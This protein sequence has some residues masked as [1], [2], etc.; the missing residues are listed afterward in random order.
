MLIRAVVDDEIHQDVHVALF[1]LGDQMVHV[2]HC[3][4]ARVDAVIIGN[5]V[6]LICEWRA[7]DRREPDDVDTEG[8]QVIEF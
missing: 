2:V 3:A 6:A 5:I 4:K 1:S 8:F 7:V